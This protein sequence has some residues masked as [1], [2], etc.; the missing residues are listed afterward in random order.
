MWHPSGVTTVPVHSVRLGT[1]SYPLLL[2]SIRDPRLHLAAVIVSI[3]I[4]GQLALGFRVSI[5]QILAAII[6]CAVIEVGWTFAKDRVVLW[7]ASAMLTGS[8]VALILR[9]VGQERGDHWTFNG[10]WYFALIAGF[11]LVSK[12]LIRWNGTHVFNP[13][14]FGLVVAFLVLGSGVIEPLDFWWGP[15]DAWLLISYAIIVVGG[16]AITSRLDLLPMA[17][18]FWIAFA[19]FI[20]ILA[21]SGHCMTTAWAL[22]PVCDGQFW[23]VVALSPEVLVFLFFMITD[24]KTIPKGRLARIVFAGSIAA[25]CAIL[26]APQTQ[27]FGAKVALLA[28]LVLLTPFR[29]MF[30]RALREGR[31]PTSATRAS[32]TP[33]Y[34]FSVGAMFGATLVVA[35]VGMVAAGAVAR[36]DPV[37]VVVPGPV[38][39]DVD[40]DAASIPTVE[41][42]AE[43]EA[44]DGGAA[45]DPSNIALALLEN[46]EVEGMAMLTTDTSMLRAVDIGERLIETE[47]A[48]EAAAT[49]DRPTVDSYHF[50]TMELDVAYTSGTQDGA[51]LMIRGVGTV[52]HIVHDG[53]GDELDRSSEPFDSEFVLSVGPT[54]RWLI[55]RVRPAQGSS[56]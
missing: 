51:S 9:I 17:T 20:G 19:A 8:G 32:A 11:A 7:P 38:A 36:P 25:L 24:P 14:N 15:V 3:H 18:A 29:S 52:E 56:A 2:P 30:D 10:W 1:R 31:V 37:A 40:I 54:G 4:L 43:V 33:R 34:V 12:Y 46:L 28:G 23:R 41:V 22:Q 13:S 45:I 39:V 49:A 48:V 21:A 42:S 50:E 55:S 6:T 53:S 44:L 16:L 47:R 35:S 5:P 27:E 26:M